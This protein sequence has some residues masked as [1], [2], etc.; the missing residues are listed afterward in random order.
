MRYARKP[1]SQF[2]KD[3]KKIKHNP[4]ICNELEYVI[5]LLEQ[6]LPLPI[7]YKDHALKGKLSDLR[8]CHILPD[9]LLIYSKSQKEI[10]LYLLRIGSHNE[11]F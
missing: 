1:S 4:K 7:K 2:K 3:Y 9:I 5:S 11:L 6:D 10:V 8:E